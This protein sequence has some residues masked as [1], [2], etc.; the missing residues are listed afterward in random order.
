MGYQFEL[1]S[2]TGLHAPNDS[3]LQ[4]AL[5]CRDRGME[6]YAELQEAEFAAQKHR[7]RATKHQHEAATDYFDDA[8]QLIAVGLPSTTALRGSTEQFY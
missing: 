3:K 6:A 7:Y 4:F 1:F 2:P 5:G 8:P